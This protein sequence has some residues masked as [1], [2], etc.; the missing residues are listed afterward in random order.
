MVLGT[1]QVKAF[2]AAK[3]Q[4]TSPKCLVHYDPQKVLIV[5]GHASPYG[6]GAVLAQVMQDGSERPVAFASQY[7]S[8]A[9]KN[10]AQVEKEG[11]AIL[12]VSRSFMTT[13]WV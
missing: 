5:A 11:L 6:V 10:Y 2:Q 13:S 12:L 7:L 3:E 1:E 9:K 4:L 8:S